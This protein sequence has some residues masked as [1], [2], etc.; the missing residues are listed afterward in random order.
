MNQSILTQLMIAVEK[1]VRPLRAGVR[2][3]DRIREEMLTHLTGVYEQ[4]LARL[5]DAQAAQQEALRRFGAP[6][7]LTQSLE[8]SLTREDRWNFFAER[9]VGWR[10]NDSATA[11]AFRV[12]LA[13]GFSLAVFFML[14]VGQ[15]WLADVIA[16]SNPNSEKV[17]STLA[18]MLT[19]AVVDTFF[20][21]LLYFKV[22][23]AI[24]GGLGASPSA[25]MALGYGALYSSIFLVSGFAIM[26]LA[27]RDLT[28]SLVALLPWCLLAPLFALI[29]AWHAR[30]HGPRE[31]RHNQWVGL[32][33]GD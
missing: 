32:N 5:G 13:V 17:L 23:D 10:S 2:K 11:Y 26:F 7:A 15:A 4:E 16:G 27:A 28:H 22:R 29:P 33:I 12:A 1:S 14:M 3:K 9:W 20:F 24:C 25:R 8:E 30:V 19:I 31:I 21:G 6:A 18:A